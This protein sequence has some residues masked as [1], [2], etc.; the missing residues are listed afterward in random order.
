MKMEQAQ[1]LSGAILFFFICL[2]IYTKLAG[3]IPFTINSVQTTK[4][5]FFTAT[6]TGEEKATAD[7]A[8]V[9]LGVTAHAA[10][11]DETKS[12]INEVTNKVVEDLKALGIEEKDIKT[13]NF[14]V[15]EDPN[16][17][18]RVL[19]AP[20]SEVP[21]KLGVAIDLPKPQSATSF[22]GNQTIE[23]HAT[24]IE[25]ANKAID[26]AT[27]DGANSLGAPSF[28][29]NDDRQKQLMKLARKKAITDAKQKAQE[30][31]D[32]AGIHLGKIVDIQESGGGGVRYAMDNKAMSASGESAP[33]QLNPGENTISVTVTLSYETL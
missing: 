1:N 11:A 17:Q 18:P 13:T 30:L 27:K 9:S 14:S 29:V 8:M 4:N 28:V 32:E 24:S 7:T 33:T 22:T 25:L 19:S 26:V 6:G 10:T 3:P 12:Q 21:S 15:N 2:F 16:A 5:N 31:A 23:V 20:P